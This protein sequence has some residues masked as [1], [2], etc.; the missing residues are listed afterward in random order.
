[1]VVADGKLYVTA[2]DGTIDVVQAGREFKKV[3]TNKLPDTLTA[4]PAIS[5]GRI[6]L[7]GWG[8]LWAIGAK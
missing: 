8:Y 3:A 6:Y 4:S 5:D 2:K 1:M 7:R